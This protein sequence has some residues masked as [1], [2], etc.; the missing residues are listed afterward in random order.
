MTAVSVADTTPLDGAIEGRWSS[1]GLLTVNGNTVRFRVMQDATAPWHTH[2]GSDEFFLVLS[3]EVTIDTRERDAREGDEGGAVTAH[4]IR[5]GQMLAVHPG[6]EHR[7][8]CIGRATL[9]VI[10]DIERLG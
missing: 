8:R 4:R 2:R 1:T 3:G 10:D 5:P 6:T 9:V 7:A